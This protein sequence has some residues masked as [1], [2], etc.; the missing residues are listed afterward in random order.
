MCVVTTTSVWVAVAPT[1]FFIPW[2]WLKPRGA[3]STASVCLWK[4]LQNAQA[5]INGSCLCRD[6]LCEYDMLNFKALRSIGKLKDRVILQAN[7]LFSAFF[8]FKNNIQ[9]ANNSMERDTHRFLIKSSRPLAF[10]S[11]YPPFHM[12]HLILLMLF[13]FLSS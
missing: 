6:F 2:N 1:C 7:K 12:L 3:D 13:F 11:L 5:E 9:Q 10:S 8:Q 4:L